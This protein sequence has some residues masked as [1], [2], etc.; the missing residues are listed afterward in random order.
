M[1][2][3]FAKIHPELISEWSDK[4]LPVTADMVTYGS[5]KLMWWKGKCGHEWQTSIKARSK[6]EGC[7]ICSGARAVEGINDL[8]TLCPEL[9]A[10]WSDKNKELRPTMV[11]IGSSKK[12][13]WKGKC[14]HE[15]TATVKSR[16]ISQSG[17]PYCSHNEVLTGFNDLATLLPHLAEEW[18]EKNSPLLPT[19]VGAFANRK[20]W[21]K[22]KECGN[23][24]NTLISTRSGGSKCPY[25]S[26]LILLKGFNDFS[27]THPQ[28][29][30]EWSERN[31]PLKPDM[32]NA[33]SR[34]NVWWKCKECGYEWKA[35]VYSRVKGSECPVCADRAVL[36]GYNDLAATDPHL[37][38]EWDYEKNKAVLPTEISRS[39]MKIVWWKCSLGHSWRG[40]ISDRTIEQKGC[41]ICEEEYLGVLPRLL[42]MFYA[43]MKN[44]RVIT[45]DDRV[46]GIPLEMYIKEEKIAIETNEEPEKM[47]ALKEHLCSKR[48]IKLMRVPY[49]M[50]MD[51]VAYAGKIKKAFRSNYVFITSDEE[52]DVLFIRQRF[53]EWRRS[54]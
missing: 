5:N 8:T 50:G 4:N 27:T 2:N 3:S 22:C 29:A 47:V 25:C 20:V 52:E 14:G 34:K 54:K 10:E 26:G 13:I 9:A 41:K 36:S 35:V 12:V 16:A 33:K 42:V 31:Y 17:C 21:W 23:E 19:K 1:D 38:A 51:E 32:I 18:S 44:L 39:S 37:L 11:T 6:G 7:P 53:F 30:E 28:L 24:W 46:I 43:K 49:K 40:R 48:E 15:W 45:D